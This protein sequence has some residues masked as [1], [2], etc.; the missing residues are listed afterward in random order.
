MGLASVVLSLHQQIDAAV[1]E[2]YGWPA[3]LPEA[4]ILTRLVALNHQRAA[5]EQAG[6]IRYLRPAYQ[7]PETQ[8][9]TLAL[10]TE[11]KAVTET[12]KA[13][14]QPWPKELAKQ[15]QAVRTLVVQESAPLTAAQVAKRFEGAKPKH[16]QPLLETL[17]A[18]SLI[19]FVEA[20]MSFA[21]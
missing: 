10:T 14:P 15:M 17:V 18:M 12:A 7:A 6:H 20:D 19:R 5:E 4:K 3:D 2:A 13:A 16:I 9:A 8:Q 11:S 21:A 1:A